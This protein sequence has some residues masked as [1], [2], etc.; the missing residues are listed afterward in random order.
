MTQAHSTTIDKNVNT[1]QANNIDAINRKAHGSLNAVAKA[2]PQTL[3]WQDNPR[4]GHGMT[5]F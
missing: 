5:T 1:E 3:F 4:P 2:K